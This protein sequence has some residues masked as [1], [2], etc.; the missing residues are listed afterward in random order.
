M[1]ETAWMTSYCS[2]M[3]GW[4]RRLGGDYSAIANVIGGVASHCALIGRMLRD[5]CMMIGC[6]DRLLS[7]FVE[8]LIA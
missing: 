8:Y 1:N 2:S 5:W 6:V 7:N 3:I 4:L